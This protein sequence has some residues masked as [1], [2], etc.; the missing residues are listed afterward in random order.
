MPCR[1]LY[2]LA[3]V[4]SHVDD[5]TGGSLSD[6]GPSMHFVAGLRVAV[7]GSFV[8]PTAEDVAALPAD[9]GAASLEGS[10]PWDGPTLRPTDTNTWVLF[11]DF[12]VGY[13]SEA[14]VCNF[15]AAW[16]TP[17]ML[18]YVAVERWAG[19]VKLAEPTAAATLEPSRVSMSVLGWAFPRPAQ[20]NLTT[21]PPPD[22]PAPAPGSIVA[23]DAEFVATSPEEVE[24]LPDGSRVVHRQSRLAPGRVSCL[25][26]SGDVL[27]D[28]FVYVAEPVVDHL[29]R[30]S[31]LAHGDLD[32][33]TSTHHLSYLKSVYLKMRA[34]VDNGCRWVGHGM[35]KDFRILNLRVPPDNLLDT[36]TLFHRMHGRYISLRF[37]ASHFLDADIQGSVHDSV[38]DARTA[39]QLYKAY[40]KLR[41]SG[42]LDAALTEVYSVGRASGWGARNR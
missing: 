29:T 24:L 7:D 5:R 17:S 13:T 38:E 2:A 6:D 11:N 32:P 28:D 27:F 36:V 34:L 12:R 42:K 25:T 33:A 20:P 3:G 10:A 26:E 4:V 14:D 19:D 40:V 31:G 22:P 9:V 16:K 35:S 23:M 37:L 39:L 1:G 41:D 30:F 18:S 8:V 15:D 21:A